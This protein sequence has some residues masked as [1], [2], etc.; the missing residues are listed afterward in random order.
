M[1]PLPIDEER[2][3]MNVPAAH[4]ASVVDRGPF[5]VWSEPVDATPTDAPTSVAARIGTLPDGQPP[6]ADFLTGTPQAFLVRM[7]AT[8]P[9]LGV[10]YHTVDQFQIVCFGSGKF[11]RHQV[12]SGTVHYAD[13]LTPYGP[14]EPGVDGVS[15][16]TLRAEQSSG[17]YFM[18]SSREVRMEQ[19][20]AEPLPPTARRNITFPEFPE[21]RTPASWTDQRSDPDGL[22]VA[23][24]SLEPSG[25]SDT[26]RIGGLGAFIVVLRGSIV[27]DNQRAPLG[28][29]ALRWAS[30][31][32]EINVTASEQGA[33]LVAV[34]FPTK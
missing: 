19:I 31:G 32:S 14:L 18:P 28:V 12:S 20:A 29:N 2:S 15:F 1:Q 33:D 34:Q 7:N 27:P 17:A 25:A 30:P 16:L 23:S 26:I 6:S 3:P 13:R 11:G 22:R 5:A 21:S 10:H 24:I 4:L 8:R 9:P